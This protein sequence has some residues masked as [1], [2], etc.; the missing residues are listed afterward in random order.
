MSSS[1]SPP[2]DFGGS[3]DFADSGGGDFGV[4]GLFGFFFRTKFSISAIGSLNSSVYGY[5]GSSNIRPKILGG[6]IFETFS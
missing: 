6:L 2:G 5:T 1:I 4:F 3:G